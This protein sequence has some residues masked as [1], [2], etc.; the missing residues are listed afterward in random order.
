MIVQWRG[1][2]EAFKMHLCDFSR[3]CY[4]IPETEFS[5]KCIGADKRLM[6]TC[7]NTLQEAI[8]EIR[9]ESHEG[10]EITGTIVYPNLSDLDIAM[11][12]VDKQS[13]T[14]VLYSYHHP[15]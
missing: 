1:V 7:A 3:I 2:A 8:G 5:K 9:F 4:L 14:Q 6:I 11:I 12:K 15:K 13:T 10:Q